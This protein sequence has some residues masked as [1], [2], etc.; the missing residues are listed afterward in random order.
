MFIEENKMVFTA[1]FGS[2]DTDGFSNQISVLGDQFTFKVL[3]TNIN[4]EKKHQIRYF[5]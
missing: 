1:R 4:T 3:L 2:G 5:Q